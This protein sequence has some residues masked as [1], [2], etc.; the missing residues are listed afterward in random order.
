[1]RDGEP[2]PLQPHGGDRKMSLISLRRSVALI[3][4]DAIEADA[5]EATD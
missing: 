2:L 4:A 3:D 5:I 1:M